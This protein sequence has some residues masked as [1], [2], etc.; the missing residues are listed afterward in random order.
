ME[1]ERVGLATEDY[2]SAPGVISLL[3]RCTL[4]LPTPTSAATFSMP[5]PASRWFLMASSTF[6]DTLGAAELFALL[7]HAIEPGEWFQ[8][9]NFCGF[10]VMDFCGFPRNVGGW[11]FCMG[12][13]LDTRR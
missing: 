7:A 2:A 5:L 3:T 13:I 8:H 1:V 11:V 10:R 4:P 9:R 12:P 6:G